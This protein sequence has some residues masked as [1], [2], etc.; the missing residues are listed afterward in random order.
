MKK[1]L[2]LALILPLALIFTACGTVAAVYVR[3]DGSVVQNV[4]MNFNEGEMPT[5]ARIAEL[6]GFIT[7]ASSPFRIDDDIKHRQTEGGGLRFYD[8]GDCDPREMQ[9][10]NGNTREFKFGMEVEV[11]VNT[12]ARILAVR[13]TFDNIY[14]Y[15]YFNG[16]KVSES[17]LTT[18]RS[19]LF[20]EHT[21]VIQNPFRNVYSADTNRTRDLIDWLETSFAQENASPKTYMV[22]IHQSRFRLTSSNADGVRR[23]VDGWEYSFIAEAGEEIQDIVLFIRDANRMAWYGIGV[24]ATAIFMILLFVLLKCRAKSK[25]VTKT[26]T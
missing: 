13:M 21:R 22:Y 4:Q 16:M 19:F 23:T 7:G 26:L 15:Y 5:T 10:E 18:T 24:G 9:Y 25:S 17:E 2:V 11:Y 1:V 20:V 3:S 6:I 14:S 12:D 8:C